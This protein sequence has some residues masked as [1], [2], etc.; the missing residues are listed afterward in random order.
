MELFVQIRRAREKFLGK[1]HK[2]SEEFDP[3]LIFKK[4][5]GGHKVIIMHSGCDLPENWRELLYDDKDLS[6]KWQN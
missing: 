4:I 6:P 5:E 2:S 3:D 1:V